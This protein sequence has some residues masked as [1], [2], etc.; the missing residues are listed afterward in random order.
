LLHPV[1]PLI[2]HPNGQLVVHPGALARRGKDRR[3]DIKGNRVRGSIRIGIDPG[4]HGDGFITVDHHR[5]VG[6]GVAIIHQ[7]DGFRSSF[8]PTGKIAIG[9]DRQPRLVLGGRR[10]SAK[11][12]E[13]GGEERARS[14][15]S[16]RAVHH[17]LVGNGSH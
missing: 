7:P 8:D 1:V 14:R 4:S 16:G 12:V 11:V 9:S 15:A 13:I 5:P 10:R 3:A 6:R 2:N 17:H